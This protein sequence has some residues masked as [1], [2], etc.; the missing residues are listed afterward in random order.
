MEAFKVEIDRQQIV[1]TINE[2]V[3]SKIKEQL[4]LQ[5]EDIEKTI[6]EYF[7][8]SFFNDKKT[9]FE[10]ALDYTVEIAFRA[11][12]DSAMEELNFKEMIAKKASELL[13]SDDLIKELAEAKVRSSLG[14]P[15]K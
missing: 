15:Q 7:K 13:K 9:E 5:M 6:G 12:I 3:Q 4:N 2:T 1:E 14:L 10:N 8:R 11:G